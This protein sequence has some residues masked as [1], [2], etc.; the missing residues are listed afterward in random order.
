MEAL[1]VQNFK[2]G[3]DTRRSEQ[4]SLPGTLVT[5]QDAHI[6]QG[7]EVE[8]RKA[9]VL[10]GQLPAGCFGLQ[11]TPSA[12]YTF[13]SIVAA[14]QQPLLDAQFGVGIV[15]YQQL[16]HYLETLPG[17]SLGGHIHPAMT[18]VLFSCCFNG[19][20]WVIATFGPSDAGPG[21]PASTQV[22]DDG[23]PVRAYSAGYEWTVSSGNG[24]VLGLQLT[25]EFNA[26]PPPTFSAFYAG[27]GARVVITTTNPA[28]PFTAVL[29]DTA[30]GLLT[31]YS[32]TDPIP[33]TTGVAA[34]TVFFLQTTTA[35][36]DTLTAIT[37]PDLTDPTYTATIN[38]LS[39]SVS[40]KTTST[41]TL[42]QVGQA[43]V[44]AVAANTSQGYSA[45]FTIVSKSD[46]GA[47]AYILQITISAPLAQG[48]NINTKNCVLNITATHAL[49]A[50]A[51]WSGSSSST[52]TVAFANG[53][54]TTTATAAVMV[55]DFDATATWIVG[56]SWQVIITANDIDYTYGA[57]NLAGLSPVAC[58]ALGRKMNLFSG[59]TWAFSATEDG[60]LW[61]QQDIGADYINITDL[62]SS[63][64]Q[65]LTAIASYQGKVALF[66][67]LQ[68]QIWT[69]DANPMLYTQTQVLQNT[70]TTHSQGVQGLGDWDVIYPSFTGFRSLRVRDS[71]LNA[72]IVDLGSP[73]DT[74]VQADNLVVPANSACSAYE[75][76]TGRYMCFLNGK[77]YVLSYYP[78]L[79]IQA[80]SIYKPGFTAVKMCVYQSKVYLLDSN[81]NVYLYGGA[82]NNTYDFCRP[83]VELPWLD[84]GAL[85]QRK[86]S[87]GIDI[88]CKGQWSVYATMQP[89]TDTQDFPN[90]PPGLVL[91]TGS[92]TNPNVNSDSTFPLM[93]LPFTATGTHIKI[94][95]LGAASPY[96]AVLSSIVWRYTNAG[97]K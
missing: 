54:A 85:V 39:A 42:G 93:N 38:L 71:S 15:T 56:Q 23:A 2:Y 21:I 41:Y 16:Q 18:A 68:V 60:T 1:V 86:T 50:S 61:E 48:A 31:Q 40:L 11:E 58:G 26:D 3:L 32:Y 12:I 28:L 20:P 82:D 37:V 65:A 80:W 6:N 94:V 91:I 97:S 74:L 51:N 46:A 90:L 49:V 69:A 76:L 66:S 29:S 36:A 43:I 17:L 53:L 47:T 88:A 70:G 33:A 89:Y 87:V 30:G 35:S 67:P 7:G 5:L 83:V 73:V 8:K 75:P 92:P 9:F 63:A 64:S 52:A 81:N 34:S 13:G 24:L 72:M 84:H 55:L 62:S 57:G 77:I 22:F 95:A 45:A 59:T 79:K 96:P 27:V 25:D 78:Q 14:T 10:Q 44:N 4:T 19:K